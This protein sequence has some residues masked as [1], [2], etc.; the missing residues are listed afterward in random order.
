VENAIKAPLKSAKQVLR[1]ILIQLAPLHQL[2]DSNRER[3]LLE[4]MEH[5]DWNDS[6]LRNFSIAALKRFPNMTRDSG[7][8]S[9]GFTVVA[10]TYYQAAATQ[11]TKSCEAIEQFW[12]SAERF[13]RQLQ[14]AQNQTLVT[15]TEPF[16]AS[17]IMKRYERLKTGALLL[18]AFVSSLV[19]A[20]LTEFAARS[21]HWEWLLKHPNSYSIQWLSYTVLLLFLSGLFV[22]RFRSFCWKV[23]LIPLVVGVLQSL[24]GP[25]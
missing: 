17:G 22:R 8:A 2:P 3:Q 24:G 1:E 19:I 13:L 12:D 18:A 10:H 23:A 5:F 16:D 15:Q 20:V 6:A 21:W 7:A 4:G 11:V 9:Q 25:R 14:L